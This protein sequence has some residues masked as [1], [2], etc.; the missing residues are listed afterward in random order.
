MPL[1][2]ARRERP[3]LVPLEPP[4]EVPD[5]CGN[6]PA[7]LGCLVDQLLSPVLAELQLTR[8]E[9]GAK[10]G[11][12]DGLRDRHEVHRPGFT[13][14][15]PRGRVDP[16]SYGGQALGDAVHGT[17]TITGTIAG[18]PGPTVTASQRSPDVR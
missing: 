18:R 5:R 10:R 14:G 4:D 1:R 6:V 16:L 3:H 9:R 13:P 15:R 12:G 7:Q 8:V 17:V 2:D 11:S